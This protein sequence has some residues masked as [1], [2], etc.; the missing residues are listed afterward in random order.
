[1]NLD[2]LAKLSGIPPA[3]TEADVERK[4]AECAD[5]LNYAYPLPTVSYDLRGKVAGYAHYSKNHIQLNVDMLHNNYDD[6]INQTL[7][8]EFAHIA[9][10]K[11]Y[12]SKGTGHGTYWKHTMRRLGLEPERCHQYKVELQRVHKKYEYECACGTKMLGGT[13]HKRHLAGTRYRCM[14][15][16]QTLHPK[17][18]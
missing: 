16:G 12:G 14:T 13:R 7:P 4:L 3:S 15:C 8:H 5:M 1:M 6:M 2:E 10:Y 11:F 9:S 17:E 18:I